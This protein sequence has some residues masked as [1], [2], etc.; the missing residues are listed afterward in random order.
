MGNSTAEKSLIEKRKKSR[1][2]ILYVLIGMIVS[3]VI[4][5][6]LSV[7]S[8]NSYAASIEKISHYKNGDLLKDESGVTYLV[9]G[10]NEDGS[11]TA[12]YF[13]RVT[14]TSPMTI[15]VSVGSEEHEEAFLEF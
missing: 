6:Y 13:A 7:L 3:V 1:D 15:H 11:V 14:I 12:A 5:H 2:V 8:D 4:V 9:T 10:R